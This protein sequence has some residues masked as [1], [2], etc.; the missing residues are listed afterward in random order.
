MPSNRVTSASP[1]HVVLALDD[2]GSMEGA[3]AEALNEAL[4]LMIAEMEVI[5]KGTKPYFK[6]SIVAFGSIARVLAEAKG[7]K[8]IEVDHIA[9][10]KGASGS[11]N[12]AEG[13]RA[14]LEILERHPGRETDFRPYV[15][16]FSDGYP[17][18]GYEQEALDMAVKLKE[19]DIAAGRP[20]VVAIGLGEANEDFMRALA[21]NPDFYVRLEGVEQLKTIFPQI[22]TVAG[23]KAGGEAEINQAFLNL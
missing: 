1:W 23:E 9:A 20:T 18:E 3:P 11:T 16:F 22:G 21:S 8:E 2:S 4:R 14:A 7:E 12:A 17:D 5:A 19:V 15:F 13:L 10:F 6:I